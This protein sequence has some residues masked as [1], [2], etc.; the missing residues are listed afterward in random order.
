[1][2]NRMK[3]PAFR[4]GFVRGFTAMFEL[5]SPHK[6]RRIYRHADTVTRSWEEIGSLLN[7]SYIEEGKRRGKTALPAKEFAA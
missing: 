2:R 5:A 3:S 4:E 7:E 1:M 6:R